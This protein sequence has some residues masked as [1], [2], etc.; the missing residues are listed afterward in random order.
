MRLNCQQ[1]A[2][3]YSQ[4]GIEDESENVGSAHVWVRRREPEWVSV[5]GD[6]SFNVQASWRK[7][8]NHD[9]KDKLFLKVS[10]LLGII[11]HC[12]C[13]GH[14]LTEPLRKTHERL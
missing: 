6:S 8:A 11:P 4:A 14:Q 9:V 10:K 3:F 2:G 5:G 1:D 13:L 12:N 7:P